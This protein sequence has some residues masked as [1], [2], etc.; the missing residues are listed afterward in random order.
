VNLFAY[1]SPSWTPERCRQ[2]V[3]YEGFTVAF[4]VEV[5]GLMML[6]RISALY[7]NQKFIVRSLGAL[8]LIETGV[9]IWLISGAG[10]VPHDPDSNIH[11]CSMVFNQAIGDAGSLSAWI[12]LLYDTI[13]FGLTL[14]RTIPP[15]MRRE[16]TGYIM[17]RMLADGI[18]Y[19]SVIFSVTLILAIMMMTT[20][21]GIKN[22]AAQTEQLISVAM[23]SRITLNLRKAARS[24]TGPLAVDMESGH[25]ELR[26]TGRVSVHST[27]FTSGVPLE[28]AELTSNSVKAGFGNAV[29]ATQPKLRE[30]GR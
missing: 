6:I 17:K 7:G 3:R 13:V 9:N 5:V 1:L 20:P 2:F 8:L 21:P 24:P 10:P 22:I 12:P 27:S 19:Y 26:G 30:Y 18:L 28:F 14:Y 23:M 29:P 25:H 15:R 16:E 4:A 11:A